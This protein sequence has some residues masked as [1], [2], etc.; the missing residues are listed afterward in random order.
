MI[1]LFFIIILEISFIFHVY[2]MVSFI[3]KKDSRHFRGFFITAVINIFMSIFIAVFVITFPSQLRQINLEMFLFIQSGIIF[4]VMLYIKMKITMAIYRRS[5]DPENFHYNVFGKKV[6]H[7]NVT[8]PKD[9]MF[10][11]MTLPITLFCGAYFV[12][13]LG[14]LK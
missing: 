4:I 12:V 5:Q 2:Y 14:C 1:A 13:K 9:V 11:F 7:K 10:Y 8:T 3:S 6:L